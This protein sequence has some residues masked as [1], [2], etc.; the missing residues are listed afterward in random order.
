MSKQTM[1]AFL[2]KVQAD[3]KLGEQLIILI[4]ENEPQEIFSKVV[5]L[6]NDNGFTVTVDD[7]KEVQREFEKAGDTADSD[8]SDEDLENVSGGVLVPVGMAMIG[9]SVAEAIAGKIQAPVSP[10][11]TVGNLLRKW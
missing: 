6:A 9:L 3:E 1:A 10:M 11:R 7:V 5:T 2:E 8:L 4:H